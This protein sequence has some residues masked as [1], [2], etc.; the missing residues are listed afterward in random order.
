[1]QDFVHVK[2]R[3]TQISP[4]QLNACSLPKLPPALFHKTYIWI[5][6]LNIILYDFLF[7]YYF[8]VILNFIISFLKIKLFSSLYQGQTIHFLLKQKLRKSLESIKVK[9]SMCTAREKGIPLF[10]FKICFGFIYVHISVYVYAMCREVPLGDSRSYRQWWP[11]WELG[12][13][14][15]LSWRSS[16]LS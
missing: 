12:T 14:L 3:W 5:F 11:T 9:L 10:I 7:S 8:F 13:E 16:K 4:Y 2:C 15:S 1:M 6:K